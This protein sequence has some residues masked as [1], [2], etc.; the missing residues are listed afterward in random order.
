MEDDRKIEL[1]EL[2]KE[3]LRTKPYYMQSGICRAIQLLYYENVCTRTERD[4]LHIHIN[5]HKP[6]PTNQYKEFTE[7]KYW[8]NQ[9]FWWT[10]IDNASETKQIRIDYLTKVIANIK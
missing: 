2:V 3:N 8:T 10:R 7:T 5:V 1:L 9:S 6:T 4:S